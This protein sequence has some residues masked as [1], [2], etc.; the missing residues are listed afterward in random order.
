MGFPTKKLI[1]I[2]VIAAGIAGV[3]IGS[4]VDKEAL[5]IEV[6]ENKLLGAILKQEQTQTIVL[7]EA[8]PRR[9]R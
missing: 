5:E 3:D 8:S 9:N 1:D 6:K 2:G 4:K 7:L